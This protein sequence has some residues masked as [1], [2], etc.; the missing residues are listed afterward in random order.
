MNIIIPEV[1]FKVPFTGLIFMW[2]NVLT[3][4]FM[5]EPYRVFPWK[6]NSG[7]AGE[8]EAD[9]RAGGRSAEAGANR[10]AQRSERSL[11][12][13]AEELT[14]EERKRDSLERAAV[15]SLRGRTKVD[16]QFRMRATARAAVLGAEKRE[17]V[18][19]KEDGGGAAGATRV[20]PGKV[21]QVLNP[22]GAY[23][24]VQ[25]N[26]GGGA[27]IGGDSADCRHNEGGADSGRECRTRGSW[28]IDSSGGGSN[29]A[30]QSCSEHV[31]MRG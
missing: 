14:V 20:K 9:E 7:A 31:R 8:D 27:G 13:A 25:W 6:N 29:K 1:C 15:V 10:A 4:S 19:E 3:Y 21:E 23:T 12:V 5:S 28:T 24:A 26:K 22:P 30:L 11:A 17:W 2:R 18:R 16:R